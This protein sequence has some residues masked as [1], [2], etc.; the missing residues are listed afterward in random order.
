MNAAQVVT[1]TDEAAEWL[2]RINRNPNKGTSWIRRGVVAFTWS[3]QWNSDSPPSLKRYGY[4]FEK[5]SILD[6]II[7]KW[8]VYIKRRSNCA[9]RKALQK[10]GIKTRL[11]GW[12]MPRSTRLKI[13][14]PLERFR[15]VGILENDICE[16]RVVIDDAAYE[17]HDYL[18]EYSKPL[19]SDWFIWEPL[20]F[21]I[22]L[23]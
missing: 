10:W 22:Y 20:M 18:P 7:E 16:R 21:F 4:C 5:M 19:P 17:N 13:S 3:S 9:F 1:D 6:T 23:P 11:D 15:Q 12:V 14:V 2:S 8:E